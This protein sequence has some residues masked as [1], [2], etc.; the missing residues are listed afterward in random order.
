MNKL[1]FAI[2]GPETE[3]TADLVREIKKSGH[4][5]SVIR[6]S[7]IFFEFNNGDFRAQWKDEDFFDLNKM[8][9]ILDTPMIG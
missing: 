1:K 4:C 8:R 9:Y 5:S 2:I 7:D 6:L 3:N